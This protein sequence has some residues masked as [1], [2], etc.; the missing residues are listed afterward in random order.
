MTTS[1]TGSPIASPALDRSIHWKRTRSSSSRM[2]LINPL[3]VSGARISLPSAFCRLIKRP[4]RNWCKCLTGNDDMGVFWMRCDML[5][6][7][8]MHVRPKRILGQKQLLAQYFVAIKHF[9]SCVCITVCNH[10][11]HHAFC[12]RILFLDIA[13][14]HLSENSLTRIVFTWK[15]LFATQNTMRT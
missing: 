10:H 9:S 3:V 6:C 8:E 7:L 2:T 5:Q 14:S 11:R 13:C 1:I 12:T 15:A 4:A